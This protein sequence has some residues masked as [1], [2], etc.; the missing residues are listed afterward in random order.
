MSNPATCLISI[1][2]GL[3]VALD[4]LPWLQALACPPTILTPLSLHS[5]NWNLNSLSSKTGI[6]AFVNPGA[7][8]SLHM[9]YWLAVLT[10]N[11]AHQRGSYLY[12]VSCLY[13]ATL[14]GAL[15]STQCFISIIPTILQ[16]RKWGTKEEVICS[17]S[18]LHTAGGKNQIWIQLSWALSYWENNHRVKARGLGKTT[19]S[20]WYLN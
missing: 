17:T 15:L 11:Q 4:S 7:K 5:L 16:M 8:L 12:H 14:S 18:W 3:L 20:S 19:S 9:H 1:L 10:K 6:T 2:Q 13:T